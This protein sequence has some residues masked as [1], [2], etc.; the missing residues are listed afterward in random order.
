MHVYSLAL[1]HMPVSAVFPNALIP[2]F[3]GAACLLALEA[4]NAKNFPPAQHHWPRTLRF[5]C[6]NLPVR[7]LLRISNSREYVLCYFPEFALGWSY[8]SFN[9]SWLPAIPFWAAF[10]ALLPHFPLSITWIF[11]NNH[12]Y[13]NLLSPGFFLTESTVKILTPEV[14]CGFL[15]LNSLLAAWHP[16]HV[17]CCNSTIT[18]LSH[19]VNWD[20]IKA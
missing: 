4:E 5:Q 15:E 17:A 11:K 9:D 3:Q 19:V 10:S 20:G 2:A 13:L 18:R 7:S 12:L 16:D 14:L 1:F 6:V 8:S